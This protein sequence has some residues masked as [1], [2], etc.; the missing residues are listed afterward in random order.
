MTIR[1]ECTLCEIADIEDNSI[2]LLKG[3]DSD[4][5]SL[6]INNPQEYNAGVYVFSSIEEIKEL[7]DLLQKAIK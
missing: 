2:S 3:F 5:Y 4:G 7:I 6:R 1:E